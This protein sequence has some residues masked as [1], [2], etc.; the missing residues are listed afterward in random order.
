[1]GAVSALTA[2]G[3]VLTAQV[4]IAREVAPAPNTPRATELRQR[5]QDPER[6]APFG[7]MLDAGVPE[8]AGLSVSFRPR[9]EVRLHLGGTHNGIRAG[10]RAGLTLLPTRGWLKP[11]LTLELGH[12]RPADARGLERRLAD[13]TQLPSPSFERV[14]YNYASAL[15][16]F[17]VE[18]PGRLT[19]FVR[20]GLSFLE[21]YG[22]GM[23]GLD[24]PFQGALAPEEARPWRVRSLR[25]NA[26]LGFLL[27]FG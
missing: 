23:K 20:G 2:L 6:L 3:L 15:M 16:G 26:K 14:G 25:P 1:M 11:A 4:A 13:R 19:F 12:A 27:S 17:E 9:R 5:A 24:E 8:G 22:P 21:L 7:L 10:A 18:M